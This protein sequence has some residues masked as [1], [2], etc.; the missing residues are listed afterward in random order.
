[1][2][3]FVSNEQ[4]ITWAWLTEVLSEAT[5]ASIHIQSFEK[6]AASLNTTDA[7]YIRVSY[8]QPTALPQQFFFKIG[9]RYSEVSFQRYIRPHVQQLPQVT[10]YHASFADERGQSNLLFDD[11]SESHH[12]QREIPPPSLMRIHRCVALLAGLHQDY[13]EHP[14]LQQE[15]LLSQRD[16]TMSFI[17]QQVR[18]QFASF[19]DALGDAL[20]PDRRRLYERILAA[21]P[22]P[23]WETRLQTQRAVTV[24]HGDAH[25][26]NFAMPL[27]ATDPVYLQ[28]WALWQVNIPLFDLAYMLIR[29]LPEFRHRFEEDILRHYHAH[30]NQVNYSWEQCWHDYRMAMVFHTVWPIFFHSMATPLRWYMLFDCAMHAFETLHCEEFL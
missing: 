1:M 10:C 30:L 6:Q 4:D 12:T 17:L 20:S 2:P 19:V 16:N 22:L 23:A 7:F 11:I 3:E 25:F 13:W 18:P 8:A 5:G 21:L 15:P 29:C 14:L 9:R 27:A 26:A 24:V 28:D